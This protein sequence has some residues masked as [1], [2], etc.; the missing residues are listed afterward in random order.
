MPKEFLQGKYILLAE[1]NEL[2]VEIAITI[3][4]E[5]GLKGGRVEDGRI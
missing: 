1:D 3:L 5:M 2:N 4:E